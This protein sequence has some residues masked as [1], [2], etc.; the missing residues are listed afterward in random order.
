MGWLTRV[1]WYSPNIVRNSDTNVDTFCP[2]EISKYG[3]PV[4]YF[5]RPLLNIILGRHGLV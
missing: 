5:K 2:P 3:Q 1:N 4:T